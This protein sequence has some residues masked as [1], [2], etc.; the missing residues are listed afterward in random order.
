MAALISINKSTPVKNKYKITGKVEIGLEAVLGTNCLPHFQA[1]NPAAKTSNIAMIAL[2]QIP[3]L[4][5]GDGTSVR[6]LTNKNRQ[7]IS[8][9]NKRPVLILEGGINF[10]LLGYVG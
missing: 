9:T 7:S 8:P 1:K 2:V 10:D 4:S 5:V 3:L 6:R